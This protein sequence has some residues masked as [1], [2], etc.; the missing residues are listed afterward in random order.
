MYIDNFPSVAASE[1]IFYF[2]SINT[3]LIDNLSKE[4]Q[5]CFY[6]ILVKLCNKEM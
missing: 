4:F 1:S 5:I 2:C 3:S 6:Y